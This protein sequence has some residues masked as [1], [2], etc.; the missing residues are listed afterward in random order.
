[1]TKPLGGDESM[2]IKNSEKICKKCKENKPLT[3]FRLRK[4]NGRYRHDCKVCQANSYRA[5]AKKNKD[6]ISQKNREK[7]Q[8][9]RDAIIIKNREHRN[10][11]REKINKR[12]R[13]LYQENKEH[14]KALGKRWLLKNRDK[15]KIQRQKRYQKNRDKICEERRQYRIN[16]LD[17]MKARERNKYFKTTYGDFAEIRKIFITLT[18]EIK[19]QQ[20][21]QKN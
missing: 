11:N 14:R 3:D 15:V 7:Y 4:D 10:I 2:M 18:K 6:R 8:A 20:E 16:N 17:K 1:M 19:C 5:W 13:E 12:R 21:Q 9:N